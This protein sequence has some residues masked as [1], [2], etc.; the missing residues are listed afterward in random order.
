M[1]CSAGREPEPETHLV[2][3]TAHTAVG[4]QLGLVGRGDVRQQLDGS[5]RDRKYFDARLVHSG[6]LD[7]VGH[8]VVGRWR[9]STGRRV[10][11]LIRLRGR[12]PG[13]RLLLL[14]LLLLLLVLRLLLV[15]LLLVLVLRRP[16]LAAAFCS[17]PGAATAAAGGGASLFGN[18]NELGA[19]GAETCCG[20]ELLPW[21]GAAVGPRWSPAGLDASAASVVDG[22]TPA[23][24]TPVTDPGGRSTCWAK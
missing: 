11:Q 16:G 5:E 22:C 10:L 4:A 21:A 14:L 20:A 7:A 3:R 12:V 23:P 17:A 13:L 24:P 9:G 19:P 8:P 15:L 1:R 6:D 2:Q 18:D